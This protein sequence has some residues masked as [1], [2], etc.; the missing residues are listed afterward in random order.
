MSKS[1]GLTER[2]GAS[3]DAR[4]LVRTEKPTGSLRGK[5]AGSRAHDA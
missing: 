4:T 2:G 5:Q 3:A 1:K